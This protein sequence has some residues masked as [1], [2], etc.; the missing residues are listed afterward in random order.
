M[1]NIYD[2]NYNFPLFDGLPRRTKDPAKGSSKTDWEGKCYN[3]CMP[4][5]FVMTEDQAKNSITESHIKEG[6]LARFIYHVNYIPKKNEKNDVE[7]TPEVFS[8]ELVNELKSIFEKREI[9]PFE[10]TKESSSTENGVF[11][12]KP[13]KTNK[14]LLK[15]PV[16]TRMEITSKSWIRIK[17]IDKEIDD[18]FDATN[19]TKNAIMARTSQNLL[20]VAMIDA[21]FMGRD[22]IDVDSIEWA[23]QVSKY[24]YQSALKLLNLT[25]GDQYSHKIEFDKSKVLNF[26]KES[27]LKSSKPIPRYLIARKFQGMNDRQLNDILFSLTSSLCIKPNDPKKGSSYSYLRSF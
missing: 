14:F 16:L 6:L 13:M 9:L 8:N 21:M 3:P 4:L 12:K 19:N 23:Y 10:K 18:L 24:S 2:V 1:R 27:F 26:I 7:Y 22:F 5:S 25:D 15:K 20:K 17:E 11:T